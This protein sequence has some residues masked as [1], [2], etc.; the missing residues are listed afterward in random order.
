MMQSK[1]GRPL[2]IFLWTAILLTLIVG[3]G[4]AQSASEDC[5]K[6]EPLFEQAMRT[7]AMEKR[8]AILLEVVK[9]CPDHSK[10][11]NNIALLYEEGKQLDPAADYYSRSAR[12]NPSFPHPYAGLGDVY[13][14]QGKYQDAADSYRR[15][16]DLASTREIADKYPELK[17]YMGYVQGQLQKSET[18]IS[19]TRPQTATVVQ[20]K[21]STRVVSENEIVAKLTQKSSTRT[22]G[23]AEHPK[24]A[25]R[26]QFDTGSYGISSQSIAQVDEIGRALSCAELARCRISIEGHTDSAGDAAYN[27]HL[28]EQRA[29]A[30]KQYLLTHFQFDPSRFQ[31][32]GFGETKPLAS[33]ATSWGRAQNRRVEFVNL[34]PTEP[35]SLTAAASEPAVVQ[36]PRVEQVP[37]AESVPEGPPMK[38]VLLEFEV[39]GGDHQLGRMLAEF[40]TTAA[41][42]SGAFNIA[43]RELLNKVMKELELGQSGMVNEG[44]AREIGRMVGA[45][46]ILT[47]S[48]SRLGGS[49]RV[50]ARVIDVESGKIKAAAEQITRYG[51]LQAL[52]LASKQLVNDL[53]VGLQNRA[54]AANQ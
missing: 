41:V 14:K 32:V 9:I 13:L 36:V 47:G 42:N 20:D 54:Q 1:I 29:A 18:M 37:T 33:N 40:M 19:R 7:K 23:A 28:S 17:N 8:K 27:Q 31:V 45:E 48:V 12:S 35:E 10:A 44:E 53:I 38:L 34:G 4:W 30:V 52:S 39:L 49:M 5:Q 25:I 15:F 3:V 11:L 50:D 46:A 26:I 43:E 6:A 16:L 2:P 21:N 51:D 22:R 24:I